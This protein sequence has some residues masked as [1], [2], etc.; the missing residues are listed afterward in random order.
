[1]ASIL[2]LSVKLIAL[3]KVLNFRKEKEGAG[4]LQA[5]QQ[6]WFTLVLLASRVAH[7]TKT[8]EV[9]LLRRLSDKV[10]ISMKI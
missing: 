1:M 7:I 6:K 9:R 8:V 10:L 3:E 2:K 5:L 4:K